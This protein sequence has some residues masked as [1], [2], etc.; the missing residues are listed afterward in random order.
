MCDPTTIAGIALT[1][2]STVV[3]YAANNAIQKARNDAMAAERV[4]QTTLDREATAVNETSRQRYDDIDEQEAAASQKLGDYFAEQTTAEPTT[5]EALPSTTSNIAVAEEAKQRGKARDF[6]KQSGQALGNLRAFGDVLGGIGRLQARDAGV[7]G[8]I[9]SFKEGSSGVLPYE[10]E[11]ANQKGQGLKLFGDLLGGFGSVA[12]SAGLGGGSLFGKPKIK[13][14][15]S[16]GLF[17]G[18]G[19]GASGSLRL[20]KLY[21]G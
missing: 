17:S 1:V 9:G 7:V 5:A 10:L 18:A 14:A 13:A 11:S 6:T 3:N 12:T 4:R 16:A 19:A 20:G 8:Q 21:G 2:G 15:G